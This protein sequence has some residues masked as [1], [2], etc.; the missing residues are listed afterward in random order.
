MN[1]IDIF[2]A[3]LGFSGIILKV[4]ELLS[5][6]KHI[7]IGENIFKIISIMGSVLI[8]IF[9]SYLIWKYFIK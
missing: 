4:L 5:I 7:K 8:I 1:K 9:S 6:Y 3:L 2:F